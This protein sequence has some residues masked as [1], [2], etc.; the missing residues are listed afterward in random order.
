MKAARKSPA[1]KKTTEILSRTAK[2]SPNGWR[3]MAPESIESLQANVMIANLNF[4]IIHINPCAIRTLSEIAGEVRQ[5]FGVEVGDILGKS[6]HTFRRNAANVERILRDPSAL[7]H[8]AEF[9]FGSVTLLARIN[10]I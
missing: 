1:K 7:P 4:E 5:A 9:S 2:S 6:I 3:H 8:Q 10:A